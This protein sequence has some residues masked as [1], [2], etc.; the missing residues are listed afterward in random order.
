VIGQLPRSLTVAGEDYSI[1]TDFRDVLRILAAY[2]DPELMPQVQ[3]YVCLT[4]LYEDFEDIP[5]DAYEEAY[6]A[7]IR[8]IDCGTEP[9]DRKSPRTM[10]WEQDERILFPAI[11]HVAGFEVRSVEYL[12]WWT[13]MGYFMEIQDGVFAQ[14]LNLRHKKAKGKKLEK[15]EQE[16]WRA[17]KDICVLKTRLTE[18]EQEEKNKLEALLD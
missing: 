8:F 4:V 11:N 6:R 18:E 5:E 17:N 12:H 9:S 14:V 1:R 10:D 16:F 3:V 15:W 7:A 13:F 2:N